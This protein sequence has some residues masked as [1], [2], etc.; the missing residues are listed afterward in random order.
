M[1]TKNSLAK[2]PCSDLGPGD[3]AYLTK[4]HSW[5][6]I[7][8]V[9]TKYISFEARINCVL[10]VLHVW[11]RILAR[12]MSDKK[13]R[14][15][16]VFA[17]PWFLSQPEPPAE[18]ENKSHF[19]HAYYFEFSFFISHVLVL[20]VCIFS[21]N[22]HDTFRWLNMSELCKNRYTVSILPWQNMKIHGHLWYPLSQKSR[23]AHQ[24]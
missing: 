20:M 3:H 18:N 17:S 5:R 2:Y 8:Y 22:P 10:G 21:K 24:I 15:A 14:E 16:K 6:T 4:E 12:H 11:R 1:S 23:Q 19:F 9:P 7:S 13:A